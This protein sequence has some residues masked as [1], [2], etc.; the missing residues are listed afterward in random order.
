MRFFDAILYGLLYHASIIPTHINGE[1]EFSLEV[2]TRDWR[3]QKQPDHN[4]LYKTERG[5][6]NAMKRKYPNAKWR[7]I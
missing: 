7:E 2:Y 4:G 6:I 5:A 1:E 3:G